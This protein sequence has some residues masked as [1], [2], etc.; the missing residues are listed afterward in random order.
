MNY[1][2][3]RPHLPSS[4]LREVGSLYPIAVQPHGT[5]QS[6]KPRWVVYNYHTGER[7]GPFSSWELAEQVAKE[8]KEEYNSGAWRRERRLGGWTHTE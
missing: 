2:S 6:G 4:D 3:K 1:P 5:W 7:R 8:M